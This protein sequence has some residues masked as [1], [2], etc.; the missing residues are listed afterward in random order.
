VREALAR[1]L[2]VDVQRLSVASRRRR[3]PLAKRS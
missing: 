3:Q 1:R 2:G